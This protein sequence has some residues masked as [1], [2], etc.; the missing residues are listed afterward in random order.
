MPLNIYGQVSGRG[1]VD[2]YVRLIP[3]KNGLDVEL[4]MYFS[5]IPAATMRKKMDKNSDG[6]LSNE[7]LAAFLEEAADYYGKNIVVKMRLARTA[8]YQKVKLMMPDWGSPNTFWVKQPNGENGSKT[9]RI[10][11]RFRT[12][13]PSGSPS[14]STGRT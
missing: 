7:E 6:Q 14:Y 10:C 1:G 13:W 5:E 9:L 11:W 2:Q 12:A 8:E 3:H 4:D